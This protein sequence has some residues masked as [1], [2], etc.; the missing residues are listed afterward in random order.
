MTSTNRYQS[1]KNVQQK[2]S[3]V[4][5]VTQAF[6]NILSSNFLPHVRSPIFCPAKIL[7]YVVKKALQ[8]L[9]NDG[10]WK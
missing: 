5:N 2:V 4:Y 6:T 10:S 3:Q 9:K 8:E 7:N 1:N